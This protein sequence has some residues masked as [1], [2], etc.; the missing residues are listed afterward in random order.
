MALPQR[1]DAHTAVANC[2]V[3]RWH[4]PVWRAHNRRYA[5]TDPGGSLKV[6]GRYHRGGD[7]FGPD[8][9]WAALYTGT[10]YGVCLGEIVR[11]LPTAE[12]VT[13]LRAYRLSRLEVR[14]AAVLDVRVL[15]CCGLTPAILLDDPTY[16]V[17]QTLAAAAIARSCEGLL[18]PSAT[19]LPDPVLVLFPERFG[20]DARVRVLGSVDPALSTAP[21]P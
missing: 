17:G 18:V 14:L 16:A 15:G 13:R 11:H 8:E 6:S 12:F 10:T 2:P 21:E 3:I 4:T 20:P 7:R 1:W 5:A 9:I 19:R